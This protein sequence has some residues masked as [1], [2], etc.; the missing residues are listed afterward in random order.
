M[1]QFQQVVLSIGESQGFGQRLFLALWAVLLA[2]LAEEVLFRGMLLPMLLKLM[3][4]W[5]A[6][7]LVSLFFGA[8]HEHL[9]A[10]LPLSFFSIALCSAYLASGSIV[11]PVAMHMC[12]NA[13]SMTVVMALG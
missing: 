6:I 12:F 13:L 5:A 4:P 7:L 9:A 1:P 3:R 10:F 2:P 8:I 11:V